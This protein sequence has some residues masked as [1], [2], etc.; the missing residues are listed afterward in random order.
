[1]ARA[2]S[3]GV[4]ATVVGLLG[5]WS[6]A[7]AAAQ[8]PRSVVWLDHAAVG[9][10][11]AAREQRE[12]ALRLELQAR[13]FVLLEATD[14]HASADQD[15]AVLLERSGASAVMW[16]EAESERPVSW[17]FVR[18]LG[19]DQVA[20]APL[21][22][23]PD[24]IDP[25]LLAIAAASLLDQTLSEP[26]APAP[27]APPRV[28]TPAE[29]ATT[30]A[31]RPVTPSPIAP[32]PVA[33]ADEPEDASDYFVQLGFV[34]AF[35]SVQPG[36]EASSEPSFDDLYNVSEVITPQ[37]AETLF[38]FDDTSAHVPD[39]DSFDDYQ[40]LGPNGEVIVPVG[41]TPASS[42]CEADGRETFSGDWP[43]K[44]CARV[45]ESGMEF[46]PALRLAF[47]LW[48]TPKL[49]VALAYQLHF[50]ISP[51]RSFGNQSIALEARHLLAG[52]RDEG[53]SL[54]TLVGLSVG[55]HETPVW[56]ENRKTVNALSGPL[57][58]STGLPL[59]FAFS[60]AWALVFT[61]RIGARFPASQLELALA[62]NAERSF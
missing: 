39:A 40:E 6:I 37:G 56:S 22:H 49:A 9:G 10:E 60:P 47:G 19:S 36:M 44:F 7:I 25:R 21:P 11:G 43:S 24:A 26:E 31:N 53:L 20:K 15:M 4:L 13:G 5:W 2:R 32:L 30:V 58:V 1:M 51:G 41:T 46:V 54:S 17:L 33:A 34:F 50:L 8:A 18:T 62:L 48:M 45:D 42:A 57:G 12:R 27:P 61:P 59:R 28:A 29:A 23:P 52:R 35:A 55:R 14:P 16:L 38:L 3:A